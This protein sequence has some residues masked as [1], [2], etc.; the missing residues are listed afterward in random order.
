MIL[1][2]MR[3][4]PMIKTPSFY[5]EISHHIPLKVYKKTIP[6]SPAHKKDTYYGK[7]SQGPLSLYPSTTARN[8][9]EQLFRHKVYKHYTP[10]HTTDSTCSATVTIKRDI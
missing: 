5:I 1:E 7:V 4:L 3:P 9:M 6:I 2:P 10:P 8:Q